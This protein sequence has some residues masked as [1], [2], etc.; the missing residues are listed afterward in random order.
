MSERPYHPHK[1]NNF[2]H[3]RRGHVLHHQEALPPARPSVQGQLREPRPQR[4]GHHLEHLL[5]TQAS[6]LQLG[7]AGGTWHMSFEFINCAVQVN[8]HGDRQLGHRAM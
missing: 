3:L 2:A 8:L 5:H 6:V 4:L 7:A 1:T